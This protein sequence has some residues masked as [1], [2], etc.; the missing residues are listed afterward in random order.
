MTFVVTDR[1]AH[2]WV[3]RE[4]LGTAEGDEDG[5]ADYSRESR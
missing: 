3:L 5:M 4:P 1:S 2:S